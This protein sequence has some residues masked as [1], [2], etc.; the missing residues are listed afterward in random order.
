[1]TL[2]SPEYFEPFFNSN[3]YQDLGINQTTRGLYAKETIQIY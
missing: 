3:I 1:M 2:N